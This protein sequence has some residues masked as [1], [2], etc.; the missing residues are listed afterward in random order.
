MMKEL[1]FKD[2]PYICS[3][4]IGR[5][6]DEIVAEGKRVKAHSPDI[7]EWRADFFQHINDEEKVL[8][9]VQDLKE[10]IEE[11][12]LLFTI[13]SEAEGGNPIPISKEELNHLLAMVCKESSIDLIDYEL[14]NSL[15]SISE[16]REVSKSN[17]KLLILS[18][19]NFD[20]TPSNGELLTLLSKAATLGGDIGKIAVMPH[21]Q[22]DV[23]RLFQVTDEAKKNL[24]IIISTMAMGNIGAI[25]RMAGWVFGSELVF[26]V[27]DKASAP[28]QVSIEDLRIMIQ[29]MKKYQV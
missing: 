29:T 12:P 6:R 5:T 9:I 7:I 4:I 13:R 22:T 8:K 2:R 14:Q 26:A 18:Y 10:I 11:I 27:G 19:H 25:S 28:G 24:S 16:I 21:N 15:D 1:Y 17:E 3:P 23:L 20:L